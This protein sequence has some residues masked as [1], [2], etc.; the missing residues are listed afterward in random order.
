MRNIIKILFFIMLIFFINI[1]FYFFS[2][3]YRFFLKKL[4]DKDSVVY[5]E[6]KV[7][8][9]SFSTVQD[10]QPESIV[11]IDNI[12]SGKREDTQIQKEVVLWK[13]YRNIVDL[14]SD[15]DLRLIEIN[16]NLFD[17]TDEYPDTY[18][19]YY[20]NN[21][22]VYLFTTKTYTEVLDIFHVLEYDL[23][24]RVNEVNNFWE[25]SFYVNLN[26]DINDSYI[27]LVIS[28]KWI[29][30]GLKIKKDQYNTVKDIL[31]QYFKK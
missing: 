11:K 28:H 14:F 18:Y 20:S 13:N 4:K 17:I 16:S 7:I 8:N 19:E 26:E 29:V 27:R 30:F 15:F 2:S 10:I 31:L 6:E 12:I 25:R 21:V 22:T 5:L 23:P 3:D 24:F 1:F 9:D